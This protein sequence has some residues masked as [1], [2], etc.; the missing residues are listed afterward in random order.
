MN[1]CPSCGEYEVIVLPHDP[2][3]GAT[4]MTPEQIKAD[5]GFGHPYC[6]NCDWGVCEFC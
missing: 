5:E 4:E 3:T 1:K 2:E 6:R